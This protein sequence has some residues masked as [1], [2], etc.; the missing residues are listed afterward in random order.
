MTDCRR[1]SLLTL[2]IVSIAAW[3]VDL[4][5]KVVMPFNENYNIF[6]SFI[7]HGTANSIVPSDF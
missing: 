7:R 5:S 6:V 1:H 4:A 3:T 2:L